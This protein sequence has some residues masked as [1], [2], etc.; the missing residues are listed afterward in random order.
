[1][2]RNLETA[3]VLGV[4]STFSPTFFSIHYYGVRTGYVVLYYVLELWLIYIL[5]RYR[6]HAFLRHGNITHAVRQFDC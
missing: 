1:M 5:Y 2:E 3:R 4:T 6:K